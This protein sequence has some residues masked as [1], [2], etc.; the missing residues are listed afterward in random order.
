MEFSKH[1]NKEPKTLLI[2]KWVSLPEDMLLLEKSQAG[3]SS[4]GDSSFCT[5]TWLFFATFSGALE[6]L[7]REEAFS[8]D[9]STS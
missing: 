2:L 6:A 7:G 3:E 5:Q 1:Q 9:T 4:L 8:K